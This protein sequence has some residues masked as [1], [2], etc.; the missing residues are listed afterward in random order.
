MS[1]LKGDA[2]NH[3]RDTVDMSEVLSL[4]LII[5]HKTSIRVV[6]GGG[7]HSYFPRHM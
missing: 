4:Y 2:M 3:I 6:G 7:T 1:S 5:C